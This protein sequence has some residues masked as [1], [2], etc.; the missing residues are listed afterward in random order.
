MS[1][2]LTNSHL[3]ILDLISIEN[4]C[5][6]KLSTEYNSKSDKILIDIVLNE[7][8]VQ[9]QV[10]TGASCSLIGL[11]TYSLLGKP[12]CEA[13][14][15]VLRAYGGGLIDV[16]GAIKVNVEWKGIVKQMTLL[17]VDSHEASNILGMDWFGALHFKLYNNDQ[18]ED[19]VISDIQ[20]QASSNA[21]TTSL[22]EST[23]QFAD[24]FSPTLGSCT[25]FKANIRLKP[26]ASPK[27]FRPYNLPFALHA[28]VRAEIDRLVS[29][30]ILKPI[31]TCEWAA[32]IVVVKK[33][34]GKL[35][36]CADFKVGVNSQ[37]EVDRYPIPRIEELFHNL[38]GGQYF[39]KIDLSEA[40]LQIESTE[41]SK[42]F[43]V[44]TTPFG[45]FQ[46]QR[47]PF[48]ISSAP[49]LF[50]K[51]MEEVIADIPH[52][53]VYLDDI[54]V[55]GK[56]DIEHIHNVNKVF[57]RLRHHGLQCKLEK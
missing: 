48:G 51:F 16:K 30:N 44:I 13:T 21:L 1:T 47:M 54:I 36:I 33:P 45:L 7:K 17:V 43:M 41:M 11:Q 56:N 20:G 19:E 12:K 24:I 42:R 46:F 3:R 14:N 26:N 50:Q 5:D 27:F 15:K 34:D 22:K 25:T 23:Q 35:R 37:I 31:G 49:G 32:P 6:V 40:Y 8:K 52:C 10:D 2:P 53:A 39:T 38:Q 18:N 28:D 57:Q 29:T 9:F 55:T 4:K